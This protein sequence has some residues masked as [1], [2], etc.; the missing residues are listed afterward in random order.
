MV[1][2][3]VTYELPLYFYGMCYS[4][5]M[6]EIKPVLTLHLKDMLDIFS[7]NFPPEVCTAVCQINSFWLHQ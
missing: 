7:L 3:T 4:Q 5:E 2:N 1:L 6:H